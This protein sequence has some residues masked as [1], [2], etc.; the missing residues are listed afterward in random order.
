MTRMGIVARGACIGLALSLVAACGGADSAPIAGGGGSGGGP[1]STPTPTPTSGVS[2]ANSP[3]G[4]GQTTPQQ[5]AVLGSNVAARDTDWGLSPDPSRLDTAFPFGIRVVTPDDFRL[6]IGS[7]GEGTMTLNGAS[8]ID[9]NGKITLL[10]FN[11]L[12]GIGTLV[13]LLDADGAPLKSVASGYWSKMVRP[14]DPYPYDSVVFLYGIPTPA[15]ALPQTGGADYRSIQSGLVLH[16][17][18]ETRAVTGTAAGENGTTYA[19]RNVL[20]S[21]DRTTYTGEVVS[22][23]GNV[24]GVIDGR[25]AGTGAAEM[26]VRINYTVPEGHAAALIGLSRVS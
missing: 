12:G 19:L 2:F 11:A 6:S 4:L 24:A 9:Q 7:L 17:D 13:I 1:T 21:A 14:A 18:F 25:F 3:F 5:F 10:G 20:L 26:M 16:V 8:G 23:D 22:A 15:E